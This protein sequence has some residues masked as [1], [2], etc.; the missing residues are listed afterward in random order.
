MLFAAATAKKFIP[1]KVM[2]VLSRLMGLVIASMAA[3]LIFTGI[4]GFLK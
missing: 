3:Q 2:S 1:Q 4:R